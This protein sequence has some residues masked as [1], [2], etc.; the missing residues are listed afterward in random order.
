MGRPKLPRDENGNIIRAAPPTGAAP[1]QTTPPDAAPPRFVDGRPNPLHFAYL[2][3][4]ANDL[5]RQHVKS[6]QS[7][8]WN[9]DAYIKGVMLQAKM[10]GV[11]VEDIADHRTEKQQ[12]IDA[13]LELCRT[14][15]AVWEKADAEMEAVEAGM[16]KV[17]ADTVAHVEQLFRK[18]ADYAGE[19][20]DLAGKVQRLKSRIGRVLSLRERARTPLPALTSRH[21]SD[22]RYTHQTRA[23]HLL[24]FMLYVGRSNIP[25][26][27]LAGTVFRFGRHHAKIAWD[28]YEAQNG[29]E[30]G[31]DRDECRGR[32]TPGR[33]PYIGVQIICPLRHGKSEIA[34]HFTAR[35]IC[36]NPEIQAVM[37]HAVA[38][39]AEK[40]LQ[41]VA[42]CFD[43]GNSVGR[44]CMALFPIELESSTN[45]R[46]KV[47]LGRPLK[48]ATLEAYGFMSGRLGINTSLQVWDDIV[49][50]SD[51]TEETTRK[52]RFDKMGGTWKSRQQG[53]GTF[54]LSICTLWHHDDTNSRII[55]LAGDKRVR[56][57][58]RLMFRVS[59]QKCGGP[60]TTPKFYPLWPEMYDSAWL[61]QQAAGMTPATYS[62]AFE[63]NPVSQEGR[64]VKELRL[65]DQ[66][67]DDHAEFLKRAVRYISLDP[68][69]VNRK[70][71]D[72]AGF[73]YGAAGEITVHS[74]DGSGGVRQSSR[75]VLRILAAKQFNATQTDLVEYACGF[76]AERRTDY[77]LT[78]QQG[79]SAIASIF[80]KYHGITAISIPAGNKDKETR[81]RRVAGM[82]DEAQV[83][84][85]GPCAVVEFPGVKEGDRL[86]LDPDFKEIAEQILDFGVA[87][88]DGLLDA[89]TQLCYYLM[90]TLQPGTGEVTRIVRE[91]KPV[92]AFAARKLAML[93]EVQDDANRSAAEED[94][95]WACRALR[96]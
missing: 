43:R 29:I 88:N 61:R 8:P 37:L 96:N 89:T 70:G 13:L 83:R 67:A 17:D 44:R 19:E 81:L 57:E 63:S 72:K 92:S 62:A 9:H 21:P 56:P 10:S 69:G 3:G 35:A 36:F 15:E 25:S 42:S 45:Q 73:V 40:N 93:K 1:P 79:L 4:E 95:A 77:V 38:R 52:R 5:A 41:Y 33:I 65:Y 32:L 76:A 11:N 22:L 94:Y 24:R 54:I 87:V 78:E 48:Q 75:E 82:L 49:P 7:L 51:Q 34:A 64:I 31:W 80:E 46:M 26:G 23:A 28:I 91:E 16:D 47:R 71:A 30:I 27:E 55:R 59:I 60:R 2:I 6:G 84:V 18:Q 39:E 86:V 58:H 20:P 90:G 12:E 68:S 50:Q 74:P 66:G 85:G 14:P 53:K